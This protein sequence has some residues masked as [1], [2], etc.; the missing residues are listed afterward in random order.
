MK[1][2]KSPGI[3]SR[4]GPGSLPG[5]LDLVS[6]HRMHTHNLIVH[7]V[8]SVFGAPVQELVAPVRSSRHIAFARQVAMYL[9]HVACGFSMEQVGRLFGRDRTTVAHGC[10]VVED[11]REDPRLDRSL[12]VL[13]SVLRLRAQPAR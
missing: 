8:A 4:R 13:E 12:V 10:H 11:R 1:R 6:L 5:N 9:S 3:A 2:R 7:A